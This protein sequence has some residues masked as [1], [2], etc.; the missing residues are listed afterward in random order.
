MLVPGDKLLSG[1]GSSTSRCSRVDLITF[2][3]DNALESQQVFVTARWSDRWVIIDAVKDKRWGS[4]VGAGVARFLAA[5]DTVVAVCRAF[6]HERAR[7]YLIHEI[8]TV[9][10][11]LAAAALNLLSLRCIIIAALSNLSPLFGI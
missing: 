9:G 3:G 4:C 5:S 7:S 6:R 1:R 11:R 10:Q 2:G 8:G